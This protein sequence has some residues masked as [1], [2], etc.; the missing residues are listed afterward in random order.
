MATTAIRLGALTRSI[1][2]YWFAREVLY[3][4][5]MRFGGRKAQGVLSF[6]EV[7]LDL[8]LLDEMHRPLPRYARCCRRNSTV[9]A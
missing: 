9:R 3:V 2:A 8:A 7:N 1:L 6:I 5:T 4:S